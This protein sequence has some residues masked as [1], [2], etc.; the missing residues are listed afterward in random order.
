MARINCKLLDTGDH[1]PEIE[2]NTVDGVSLTLPGDFG[3]RWNILL[4]YRGH[5]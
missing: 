1:F 5:W 4:F 3:D 2:F